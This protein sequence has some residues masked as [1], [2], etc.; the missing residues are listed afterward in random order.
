MT[1]RSSA[2]NRS[3]SISLRSIGG[4]PSPSS[5]G[6]AR[7]QFPRRRSRSSIRSMRTHRSSPDTSSNGWSDNRCL[8]LHRREP[9]YDDARNYSHHFMAAGI[10]LV[11]YVR[12]VDSSAARDRAGRDRGPSDSGTESRTMIRRSAYLVAA[13]A[14]FATAPLAA[15]QPAKQAPVAA[16]KALPA[17]GPRLEPGFHSYQPAVTQ[18]D[19]APP[20]AAA[21]RT[22]ITISTLG[23]VLLGILLII[24]LT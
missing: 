11:V 8:R 3:T 17:A 15:Q 6:S 16:Q 4:Q 21:D 7:R 1:P 10:H 14:C 2:C 22:V 18:H 5:C 23:L 9:I 24:L 19:A 12:R 20:M 13:V